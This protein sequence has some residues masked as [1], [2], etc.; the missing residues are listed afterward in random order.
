[1]LPPLARTSIEAQLYMELRP[2]DCGETEFPWAS[3]AVVELDADELG[4][5][6]EGTCPSCGTPREFTFRLPAEIVLA[7][8]GEVRYG[9]G[10]P[11][12]LLD[13]GEWLWVADRYA[14]S[15]PAAAT[16]LDPQARRQVRLR[17]SAAAA[18]M[19]EILAF[20]PAGAD[21]VPA[22][23]VRS[24]MGRAVYADEPGRFDRYRL[25]VVRDTYRKILSELDATE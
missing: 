22:E 23:A 1:M 5:R 4:S 9:D 10:G 15:V 24:E 17:V 19:D 25:E 18:A 11:S 16:G 3:S 7:A 20:L 8:A 2:C 14:S 13:P 21:S 12:E 6:Y